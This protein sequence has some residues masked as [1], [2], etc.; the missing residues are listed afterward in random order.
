MENGE[1]KFYTDK[2]AIQ[3]HKDNGTDVSYFIY[4]E[5]EIHLNRIAAGS[6][7]EWHY[8]SR[9]EET[10]LITK[11][12][13]TAYWLDNG[14]KK[15]RKIGINEIV[16]V[17]NSTHTFANETDSEVEFVVFRFVPDHV[18]KKEIIKNDKVNVPK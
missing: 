1:M 10:L 7:Q 3:I 6:V 5:Y 16:R 13:L 14:I 17:G 18:D 8:H 2:D 15:S 4:D 12:E 9:I 11:G